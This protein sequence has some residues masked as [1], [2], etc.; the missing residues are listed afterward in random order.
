MAFFRV[1]FVA[2]AMAVAATTA[3]GTASA[4]WV[5]TAAGVGALFRGG[6]GRPIL[7]LV[8]PRVPQSAA[9]AA[10]VAATTTTTATATTPDVLLS[11]PAEQPAVEPTL[12]TAV[13][14]T[15]RR[16]TPA[17][18]TAR[19]LAGGRPGSAAPRSLYVN[20]GGG[21]VNFEGHTWVSDTDPLGGGAPLNTSLFGKTNAS[22]LPALLSTNRYA[23]GVTMAFTRTVPSA[24]S[25]RL[26]LLWA[27]LFI[28]EA[29]IR[30]MDVF[31]SIDGQQPVEVASRLDVFGTVGADTPLRLSYPPVGGPAVPIESTITITLQRSD[32]NAPSVSNVFLSAFSLVEEPSPT[33]TPVP[34][35]TPSPAD[36]SRIGSILA[37]ATAAADKAI[38]AVRA[39]ARLTARTNETV[40]AA[41]ADRRA[42]TPQYNAAARTPELSAAW[43]AYGTA[44]TTFEDEVRVFNEAMPAI[45][46]RRRMVTAAL[47]ATRDYAAGL[48]PPVC[49]FLQNG[50]TAGGSGGSTPVT[51]AEIQA[52]DGFALGVRTEVA[53]LHDAVKAANTRYEAVAAAAEVLR[54]SLGNLRVALPLTTV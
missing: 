51:A 5:S 3:A 13:A 50:T 9:A 7:D 34:T 1:V 16:S 54:V 4:D 28:T 53:A 6:S 38:P 22:G 12:A 18:W 19:Q 33:P 8:A 39:A 17:W 26:E 45:A 27:E 24:S 30:L 29:N 25:Y 11:T 41:A 10:A 52:L 43:A 31:V 42:V 36:P 46:A 48:L 44:T 37:S 21:F 40:A 15:T 23:Q 20:V 32:F 49:A 2:A 47:T 14:T 35:T